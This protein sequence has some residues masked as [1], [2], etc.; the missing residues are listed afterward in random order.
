[1]EW[2]ALCG[3]RHKLRNSLPSN[4]EPTF[5]A[6]VTLGAHSAKGDVIED[7][8]HESIR[9]FQD[10]MRTEHDTLAGVLIERAHLICDRYAEPL[11]RLA[12]EQYPRFPQ[13]TA[14]LEWY[15][16]ELA[17]YLMRS[18]S[19]ERVSVTLPD[20][21]LV[22]ENATMPSYAHMNIP[23]IK[24]LRA[25]CDNCGQDITDMEGHSVFPGSDDCQVCGQPMPTNPFAELSD[26]M[27]NTPPF[28]IHGHE[29]PP[30]IDF[31]KPPPTTYPP[32]TEE[33]N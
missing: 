9:T 17:L 23:V 32:A 15:V 10:Y 1:M 19:Q 18:F 22:Y 16:M 21:T 20:T 29:R 7:Y 8:L 24:A 31:S 28:S 25:H 5:R 14:T 26:C 3:R 12:V 30:S 27:V 2:T 13:N 33:G 4:V 6:V 11:Y